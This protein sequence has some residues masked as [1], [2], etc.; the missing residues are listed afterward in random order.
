MERAR[1][2]ISE[3][4]AQSSRPVVFWS[5]G[6]D[7]QLLL[8]LA[9]EQKPEI[10][11]LWFRDGIPKFQAEFIR[12]NDLTVYSY[13]PMD[14]YYLPDGDG[15]SLVREYSINGTPFPVIS[16]VGY[17][18][19]CGLE[20]SI[21]RTPFFPFPWDTCLIGWKATDG[22]S[23]T[24]LNPFPEDGTVVGGT[25]FYG[26]LRHMTDEQVLSELARLGLP[27]DDDNDTI[28][29]CTN[30]LCRAESDV[31]CPKLGQRVPPIVWDSASSLA[32]FRQR[33]LAA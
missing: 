3:V 2:I 15:L 32:A 9:R 27:F 10:D 14:Q 24:G 33:F 26:P 4:L 6:K 22:H 7:S 21:E 31:Y 29:K 8:H 25:R 20:L 12:S 23:I 1:Q 17:S 30:C 19:D 13:A 18:D 5:G 16:D 11:V 28:R